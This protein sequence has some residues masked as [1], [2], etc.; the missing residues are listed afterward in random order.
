M[1]KFDLKKIT[2]VQGKQVFYQLTID[3]NPDFSNL[4]EGE[5]E[6]DRKTGVLDS[7]E[8][9]LE[10]RY[11][12]NLAQIYNAMNRVANNEHVP[13]EKYHELT[14]R[15]SND[16][17]KDYEFKHGDLR[18]YAIKTEGGKIIIL[19]GFKNTQKEDIVQMRS[20][21]K[22]FFESQKK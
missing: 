17:Y 22:Q 2:A 6:N 13:R 19:G 5:T 16:P 8:A 4:A 21:K 10:S 15:K 9:T 14:E 7:Y 18:V 3:D 12:K 11:K 1:R 20:L